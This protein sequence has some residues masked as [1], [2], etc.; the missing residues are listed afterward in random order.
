MDIRNGKQVVLAVQIESSQW[1]PG[2]I[3]GAGLFSFTR[4]IFKYFALI[5]DGG[6]GGEV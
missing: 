5:N 1:F 4:Q 2:P 6:S 3:N